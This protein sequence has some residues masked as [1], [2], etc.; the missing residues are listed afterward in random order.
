MKVEELDSVKLWEGLVVMADEECC[1]YEEN[2][3]SPVELWTG[4]KT[5]LEDMYS[6]GLEAVSVDAEGLLVDSVED[7]VALA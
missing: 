1:E 6:V 3:G 7:A 2:S 4:L 5:E